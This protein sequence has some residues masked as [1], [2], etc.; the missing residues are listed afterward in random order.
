MINVFVNMANR[1][2]SF[3]KEDTFNWSYVGLMLGHR[4]QDRPSIKLI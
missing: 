3:S 4:R 2:S 1:V